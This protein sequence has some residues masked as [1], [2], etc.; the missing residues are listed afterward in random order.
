[1]ANYRVSLSFAQLSDAKLDEFT[2]NVVS[3]MTGNT[4]YPTPPVAVADISAA[5]GVCAAALAGAA[6]GGPMATALKYNAR[7]KVLVLLLRQ[8]AY[9]QGIAAN[10][11]AHMPSSGF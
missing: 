10:D 7:E 11:L 4:N 8:D 1:M 6:Q 3:S 2:E 5:S 9:V